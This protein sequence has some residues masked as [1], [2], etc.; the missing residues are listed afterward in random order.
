MPGVLS[1]EDDA[2]FMERGGT[3][4]GLLSTTSRRA[5]AEYYAAGMNEWQGT[6][7]FKIRVRSIRH[8][9]SD[10]SPFSCSPGEQ[11]FL[12]PPGVHLQPIGAVHEEPISMT[13]APP[14]GIERKRASN[15]RPSRLSNLNP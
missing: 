10:I 4:M 8:C 5:L 3:E 14:V 7:L 1:D 15:L 9:G 12:H 11:E 13:W 6:L 2:V